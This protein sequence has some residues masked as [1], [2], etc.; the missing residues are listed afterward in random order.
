MHKVNLGG[1]TLLGRGFGASVLVG[2]KDAYDANSTTRSTSRGVARSFRLDARVSWSP[3]PDWLV[4]LAGA[5][6]LQPY[7]V[8]SADGTASPRRFEGGVTKRFGL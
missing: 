2:Y 7:R 3:R 4:F 5:D 6:L 1:R 8:E